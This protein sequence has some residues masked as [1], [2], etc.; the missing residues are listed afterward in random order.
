MEI[1]LKIIVPIV[2]LA[3]VFVIFLVRRN[4][5]DEKE[6]IEYFLEEA[7]GVDKEET[8]PNNEL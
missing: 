8:E 4:L 7:D 6:V 1:N 2:I 5:K 3:I